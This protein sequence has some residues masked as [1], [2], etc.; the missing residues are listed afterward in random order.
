MARIERFEEMDA[1]Q[2][3]EHQEMSFEIDITSYEREALPFSFTIWKHKD[4]YE[5]FT[6]YSVYIKD[7]YGV[8]INNIF[9][10]IT[11]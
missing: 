5:D 7:K 1:W 9:R 10:W 3:A 11:R 8:Y 2:R 6:N 4:M